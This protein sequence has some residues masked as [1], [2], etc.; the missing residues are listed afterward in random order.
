M[1][2]FNLGTAHGTIIINSTSVNAAAG[3]LL[4]LGKG[5]TTMGLL[6]VAAFA[7]V[8]K[9]AA[10]LEKTL[11]AVQAVSG[12]TDAQMR[13]LRE[14]ALTL[15]STTAFSAEEI[16]SAMEDLAKAGISVEEITGGAAE[17]VVDLAAAAGDELPGGV[18]QGA[19]I[20]ANA[21]KTFGASADEMSHFADVLVGA[22]ASSTLNVEDLAVSLRY[23]GPIASSLGLTIDDLNTVL[24]ILGD[25]GIKGSTAGTSLRG[26]L[27]SLTPTTEKATNVMKD[28]GIITEDGTNRFYDMNGALKPI[29]EVMQI[30]GDATKDLSEQEKVA[31]FNAIFQRRAMNAAMIMAEQGAAGFNEY[32]EA[33]Q[34]ID[35]GDVAATKLD[36]LAGDFTLLRN[37]V[38]ALIKRVGLP[39]QDMVR[40]WVQRLTELVEKLEEIDP[41]L[42]AQ[43]VMWVGVAGAVMA[44]VGA[45]LIMAGMVIKMVGTFMVLI[46]AVQWV[47]TAFVTLTGVSLGW[48]LLVIA[49]IAAVAAGFYYAYTRLEGFRTAID[50]VIDGL[51]EMF[52]VFQ[53]IVDK[54]RIIADTFKTLYDIWRN[55][56]M[57]ST[58]FSV[59]IGRMLSQLGLS[60]ETLQRVRGWFDALYA[61]VARFVANLRQWKTNFDEWR[62]AIDWE[63]ILKRAGMALGVLLVPIVGLVA[64]IVY[65]Y[66]NVEW[67]RNGVQSAFEWIQAN[68]VPVI[69][70]L[71]D[72]LWAL[73]EI[74]VGIIRHMIPVWQQG[75]QMLLA[76]LDWFVL[77]ARRAWEL[78]GDNLVNAF[79]NA[80]NFI[81][82]IVEAALQV[83]RG[84]INVVTGLITGDWGRAW[85]GIK[86]IFGGVWDAIYA[87][88]IYAWQFL[89]TI[90]QNIV[91]AVRLVW[92][93][94]WKF[95]VNVVE[96]IWAT[97]FELTRAALTGIWNFIKHIIDL[98]ITPFR[99]LYNVLVGN[100]IIPDLMDRMK[101]VIQ[102]GLN[103]VVNFFTGL[104]G[105]VIGA[106]QNLVG[107]IINWANG[108]VNRMKDA[109]V[110]GVNSLINYMGD[111]P[112]RILAAVGALGSLLYQK[113]RD[114]IQGLINGITS[115]ASALLD[116]AAG[117]AGDVAG[118]IGG[119]LGIGSP[120]KVMHEY[121]E[122]TV[123][124]FVN[125]LEDKA[126]MLNKS[127]DMF[128]VDA[129]SNVVA[130]FE[131]TAPT[132]QVQVVLNFPVS[133]PETQGAV[134]E[135]M[136]K[137]TFLPDLIRA[138]RT[139]VG[140]V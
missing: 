36:N 3:A 14:T 65:A 129:P 31:A 107:Q 41:E 47:F 49:L 134:E 110:N 130:P 15:G 106:V 132:A 117:L 34:G 43:I 100:S 33:I 66:Q 140:A 90:V 104:P 128:G 69:Q 52:G 45:F 10:D 9:S 88:I 86:Q 75:W 137:K 24:A 35:A 84:V 62:N 113:G 57:S 12:A 101:Q 37:K 6:G 46:Q 82:Q 127:M 87:I 55:G 64:A 112:R 78:F 68:V 59:A 111:I 98:I 115:M 30:L 135:I 54:I 138:V 133:T 136:D 28:L 60:G 8:V 85:D 80:W 7:G 81:R 103:A 22:A 20:I 42:L 56:E 131:N 16:A 126:R 73:G 44:T 61:G 125:G 89:V 121:G 13:V 51:Q 1:A 18:S 5:M 79:R 29:P 48:V 124:G 25:R 123:E 53:P 116:K 74:V 94:G 102:D 91:D 70:D 118:A 58:Q 72:L 83:I 105:R 27:L 71:G 77:T 11:S 19:E 2:G 67:F 108:V 63:P 139:G 23:A 76:V 17:A 93:S 119:A 122:W 21:M 26:V 38:D 96:E 109:F 32:S 120:S 92:D 4:G 50:W 97:V 40:G 95:I 99:N 114:L 39:L